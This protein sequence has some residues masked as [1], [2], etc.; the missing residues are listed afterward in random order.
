LGDCFYS[1]ACGPAA[2]VSL[3]FPIL[4]AAV[5]PRKD[6]NLRLTTQVAHLPVLQPDAA[7]ID[8]GSAEHWVAVPPDRDAQ[9][10]RR[11]AAFTADLIRLADWLAQCGIKTVAMEATGVYWIALFELLESRGFEVF[12]VDPRQ[13]RT[14]KGRPKTDTDDCRWIQRLHA[15]GLLAGSFRPSDQIVVLRAYLRQ[16][17]TLVR[18]AAQHVQHIQKALEQMNVKL[19]EVVSDV[20]GVTGLSILKAILAGQ[21]D[22]LPLAK[23]RNVHCKVA[24]AGLAQALQGNWRAEHLFA[25]K[26]AVALWE[27]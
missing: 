12:L 10:I 1:Y 15:C 14:V 27:S 7:G 19:T 21:R 18:Y 26:Q 16:K 4:E 17:Q 11:F 20:T 13:T 23:L 3:F 22:P 24:E 8:V 25:L 6:K 5:T 2:P 9:P